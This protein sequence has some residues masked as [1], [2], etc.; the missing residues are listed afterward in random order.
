MIYA[1]EQQFEALIGAKETLALVDLDGDGLADPGRL[2]A[3]LEAASADI[4][5][6]LGGRAAGIAAAQP[7]FLRTACIHIARWHLSGGSV[8]EIDPV[9]QRRD[10]YAKLLTDLADGVVGNTGGGGEPHYGEVSIVTEP[11]AWSRANRR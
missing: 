11:R 8:T 4:D 6:I 10:A 7:V 9:K 1:T 3:A 5:A 2:A